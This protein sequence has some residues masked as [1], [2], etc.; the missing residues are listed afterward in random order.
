LLETVSTP[1]EKL[2]QYPDIEAGYLAGIEQVRF[3]TLAMFLVWTAA[4]NSNG[5]E[6]GSKVGRRSQKDENIHNY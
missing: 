6:H 3:L 5:V 2:D 4:S 1:P